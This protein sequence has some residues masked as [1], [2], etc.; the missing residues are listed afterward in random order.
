MECLRDC[1]VAV[2]GATGF[3]GSHLTE[4]LV[5]CGAEV[6]AVARTR[7]R[8]ANLAAV[9]PRIHLTLADATERESIA[10]VFRDFLP[11][12]VFH[13]A[14]G[15]D[16]HETFDQMR[17]SLRQNAEA[18]INVLEISA[19]AKVE[20]F[21]FCD[22]SKVYGNCQ[23]SYSE[24]TPD[25]PVCSYA[26]AKSAAW[27]FCKLYSAVSG[28]HVVALRPTMIYGPRQNLNLVSYL[29]AQIPRQTPVAL[30]GGW[31]TRDPLYV[32]DAVEALLR[33]A[34]A[35]AAR[36]RAI[37]ISGGEEMTIA[38]IC[39]RAAAALGEE[40]EIVSEPAAVRLTEVFRS[41]CDNVDAERLLMGWRP[42]IS[43]EQGLARL[44][45]M[46]AAVRAASVGA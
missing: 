30:Q 7:E 2:I 17:T 12:K 43:L 8:L 4:R 37:P 27:R 35:P 11:E 21:V 5:E 14:S 42:R 19:A 15:R 46:P 29:L 38:D 3:I 22:S 24:D 16:G 40:V 28:G 10:D 6:L 25:D 23:T 13:L 31:Q 36:N 41:C 39:R 1:K 44:A 32:D 20:T 9:L 26:I 33:A 34:I 18:V 45:G